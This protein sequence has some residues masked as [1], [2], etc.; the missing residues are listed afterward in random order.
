MILSGRKLLFTAVLALGACTTS[1]DVA[2]TANQPE[3]KETNPVIKTSI[4]QKVEENKAKPYPNLSEMPSEKPE[5]Y[6]K[7]QVTAYQ[8]ELAEMGLDLTDT[9]KASFSDASTYRSQD[10]T[11]NESYRLLS[12][13]LDDAVE[14]L[15]K[16]IA[17]DRR[18]I[19]SRQ[20][21]GRPQLGGL[22]P[23]SER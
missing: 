17:E 22:P 10:V 19:K 4:A 9:L 5:Y 11:L 7:K 8:A 15:N 18:L 1:Q 14:Q 23:K 3:I 13:S 12:L 20:R 16:R 21:Q 2:I 6:S